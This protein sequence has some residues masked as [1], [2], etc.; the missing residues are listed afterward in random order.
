MSFITP[1]RPASRTDVKDYER[2]SRNVHPH[3]GAHILFKLVTLSGA[4]ASPSDS[5]DP[6]TAVDLDR[7]KK[8]APRT[9][10]L[11]ASVCL[12]GG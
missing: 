5:K 12:C 11:R 7:Y 10:I 4:G 1:L 9:R 3:P 6:H 2:C 8:K